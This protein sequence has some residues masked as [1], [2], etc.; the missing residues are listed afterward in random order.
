MME[1][2]NIRN[3][4]DAIFEKKA[5]ALREGERAIEDYKSEQRAMQDTESLEVGTRRYPKEDG[6]FWNN[7]SPWRRVARTRS[8]PSL[9]GGGAGGERINATNDTIDDLDGIHEETF[10]YDVSD[11]ELEALGVETVLRMWTKATTSCGGPS[12]GPGC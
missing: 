12:P 10:T 4:A 7:E 3:R 8:S 5:V 6:R 1:P 9:S 11:E 2:D